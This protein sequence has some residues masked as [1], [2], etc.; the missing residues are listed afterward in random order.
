MDYY[1]KAAK[2]QDLR[3][4]LAMAGVDNCS[5][6]VIGS[7]FKVSGYDGE[8]KPILKEYPEF[9]VNIQGTPVDE[10]P[11]LPFTIAPPEVPYRV[12]A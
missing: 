1:L 9:H 12:W 8:G 2:E 7:F 11:L 3:D 10:T 4:A 6:D 5:I